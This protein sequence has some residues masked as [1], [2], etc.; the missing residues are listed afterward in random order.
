VIASDKKLAPLIA[1][2]T[3]RVEQ[4]RLR[5]KQQQEQEATEASSSSTSTLGLSL[6]E[7]DAM[8]IDTVMQSRLES[9]IIDHCREQKEEDK[10]RCCFENCNKLFRG[11]QFMAKHLKM[12]HESFAY[13]EL[14]ANV[15]EVESLML[16]R[17]SAETLEQQPLPPIQVETSAGLELKSVREVLAK[18]SS[19]SS[20]GGP[21]MLLPPHHAPFAPGGGYHHNPQF[22]HPHG[23][24]GGEG[25]FH[26]QAPHQRFP[27]RHGQDNFHHEGGDHFNNKRQQHGGH[28]S[29]NK[30]R[31]DHQDDRERDR[32]RRQSFNE[33]NNNGVNS[34]PAPPQPPAPPSTSSPSL[35]ITESKNP[36]KMVSYVDVDAPKVKNLFLFVSLR[37]YICFYHTL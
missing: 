23:Q 18:S 14:L 3:A 32:D 9:F 19:S 16:K 34:S 26:Y 30:R 7:I 22:G 33:P 15:P 1:E 20:S 11:A 4:K 13:S 24:H 2:L 29:G 17:Y 27:R 10:C 25:A 36:R 35:V 8:T 28:V 21:P 5:R 12:K 6:N 31:L 37:V